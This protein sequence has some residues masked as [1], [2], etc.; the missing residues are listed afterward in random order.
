MIAKNTITYEGKAIDRFHFTVSNYRKHP[1]KAETFNLHLGHDFLGI[2]INLENTLEY[3]GNGLLPGTMQKC[4]YNLVYLPVG[5]Y[6]ITMPAGLHHSMAIHL[7]IQTIGQ[8]SSDFPFL[9]PFIAKVENGKHATVREGN[10]YLSPKMSM[11]VNGMLYNNSKDEAIRNFFIEIKAFD[12]FYEALVDLSDLSIGFDSEPGSLNRNVI[13]SISTYLLEHLGENITL[14]ALC[15]KFGINK[16]AL[17][18]GF[19]F[20][21]GTT[22]HDFVVRHRMDR[23]KKMLRNHSLSVKMIASVLGYKDVANFTV[24]YKKRFNQVPSALRHTDASEIDA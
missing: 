2:L 22:V 15:A 13:V 14:E 6:E 5:D 19:K 24:A 18:H 10:L 16:R 9:S 12:I 21:F 20:I 3:C 1:E 17:Q 11:E 7:D 8:F 4:Q 23:A